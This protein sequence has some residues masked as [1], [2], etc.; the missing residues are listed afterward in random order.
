M[1]VDVIARVG[2]N[3]TVHMHV[4]ESVCVIVM[5]GVGVEV[6]GAYVAVL[7]AVWVKVG[8]NETVH[9]H[10]AE[11]VSVGVIVMVHVTVGDGWF[12]ASWLV[13][14]MESTAL[15]YTTGPADT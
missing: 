9:I 2:V 8:V 3:E 13:A 5:V 7:V 4:A 12:M 6:P 15:L 10:V 14:P 1:D 11:S